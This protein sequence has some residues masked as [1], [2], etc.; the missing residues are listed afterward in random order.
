MIPSQLELRVGVSN[1]YRIP[2]TF[3]FWQSCIIPFRLINNITGSI[4]DKSF[5]INIAN[6]STFYQFH[7]ITG[8]KTGRSINKFFQIFMQSNYF[9]P[10]RSKIKSSAPHKIFC[11]HRS[12]VQCDF[13]SLVLNVT[14]IHIAVSIFVTRQRRQFKKLVMSICSIESDI[15]PDTAVQKTSFCTNFPR[16]IHLRF[17]F[18]ERCRIIRQIFTTG[19]D[20]GS[21]IR[22]I[23]R[24]IIPH[25]TISS[26]HLCIRHPFR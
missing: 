7:G 26:T 24:N 21:G 11:H 25:H 20:M 5:S 23:Q 4:S 6:R 19:S 15:K 17:H 12:S 1:L 16:I 18:L 2:V 22:N 14:G 10:V 8:R 3:Y 9:V 13:P